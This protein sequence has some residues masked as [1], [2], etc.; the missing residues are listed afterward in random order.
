MVATL[1]LSQGL[2]P[3][4]TAFALPLVLRAHGVDMAGAG[5]ATLLIWPTALKFLVGPAID[6]AQSDAAQRRWLLAPLQIT[7]TACFAML[8]LL[9]PDVSLYAMIGLIGLINVIAAVL[10]VA[11]GGFARRVLRP[12][13]RATGQAAQLV[14]YYAGTIAASGGLLTLV[15]AA[16]WSAG[17]LALTVVAAVAAAAG[18]ASRRFDGESRPNPPWRAFRPQAGFAGIAAVA[19]LLDLP[20]NVGISMLGPFLL[21]GGLTVGEAARITG[22]TG[23]L[24][25]AAGALLGGLA[26]RRKAGRRNRLAA[27]GAAQCLALLPLAVLASLGTTSHAELTAAVCVAAGSAGAFNAALGA[28]FMDRVR[29]ATAATELA[30]LAS[31]HS[32]SY[33][34]AGP[35]AGIGATALGV[36]LLL[37]L[38]AGEGLLVLPLLWL[39]SRRLPPQPSHPSPAG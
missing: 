37:T 6:R 18:F 9:P 29:S 25:A 15:E 38:A 11:V 30:L 8:A 20:Q 33:V 26:A 22:G 5:L 13:E 34:I 3:G 1:S 27:L 16:G 17:I 31:L 32:L 2:G 21:D 4:L 39:A 7:F 36:P 14:A 35:L 10:D 24:A 23:L 12:D 19:V 28:W